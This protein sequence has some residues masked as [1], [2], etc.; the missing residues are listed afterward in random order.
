MLTVAFGEF[1][2]AEGRQ[3]VNGAARSARSSRSTTHEKIVIKNRRITIREVPEDVGIFVSSCNAIFSDILSMKHEARKFVLKVLYFDQTNRRMNIPQ[4][5]LNDSN[6]NQ[7]WL[8]QVI[9]DD[10]TWV[11]GYD[12]KT[13][14]QSCQWKR[15]QD[16]RPKKV[17]QVWSTLK[18]L[19]GFSSITISAVH[20]KF[21]PKDRMI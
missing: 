12:T 21:L 13:K 9:T 20:R 17:R 6:A 7:D 8:E 14:T 16:L 5:L 19:L 1:V 2:F 11:H 15:P 18:V 3:D 10:E 4:Q